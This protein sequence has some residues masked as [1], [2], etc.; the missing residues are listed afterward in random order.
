MPWSWVHTK[1]SIHQV[2]HHPMIDF[3]PLPASL[4]SL[5]GPCCTQL[6][7]FPRSWVWPMNRV[8]APGAP[9]FNRLPSTASKYSS[10][11]PGSWPSSG[12]P[13]SLDYIL[14]VHLQTCS[15]TASKCISEFT[16]SRPPSVYPNSLDHG[17]QV[18][19]QTRSITASK[20]ISQFT[21]SRAP[22]ASLNQLDHGLQVHL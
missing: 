13:N 3:L 9:P 8:S 5:G 1:Y 20:C 6:S 21:R 18:H 22:S 7:T 2:L 4:S 17:L 14:Q 19:L 15:I 10:N 12:S 16:W 11:L